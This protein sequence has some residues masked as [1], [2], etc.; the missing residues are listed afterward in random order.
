MITMNDHRF[1]TI[2]GNTLLETNGLEMSSHFFVLDSI[3]F[4]AIGLPAKD[5]PKLLH[6][7][8]HIHMSGAHRHF[9]HQ[10]VFLSAPD[11]SSNC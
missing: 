2:N 11:N 1:P 9:I 10:S 4:V 7:H 3:A 5:S 8:T 6:T